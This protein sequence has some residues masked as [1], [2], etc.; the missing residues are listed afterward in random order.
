MELKSNASVLNAVI[1]L[2]LIVPYGIEMDRTGRYY[3]DKVLLIV[4]YGI[5][6]DQHPAALIRN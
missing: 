3:V 2:L 5:E 1:D 6:I 4:P